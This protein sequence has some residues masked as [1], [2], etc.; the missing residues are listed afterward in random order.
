MKK[1]PKH[2]PKPDETTPSS[3]PSA[4]EPTLAPTTTLEPEPAP[5]EPTIASATPEGVRPSLL[6]ELGMVDQEQP[7]APPPETTGAPPQAE[8]PPAPR[9]APGAGFER[10]MVEL[11]P[12]LAAWLRRAARRER[13]SVSGLLVRLAREA[14]ASSSTVALAPARG[15]LGYATPQGFFIHEPGHDVDDARERAAAPLG[16]DD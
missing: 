2:P 1:K 5:L 15:S 14:R 6:R 7:P 10:V 16:D 9:A 13:L 12:R 3:A 11:P 4:P 8:P